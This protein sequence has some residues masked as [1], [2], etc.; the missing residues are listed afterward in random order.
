LTPSLLL[1][2]TALAAPITEVGGVDPLEAELPDLPG[3]FIP[4]PEELA[5]SAADPYR[6][7]NGTGVS[8]EDHPAVVALAQRFNNSL[9]VFCTGS[10]I[11]PDWI[12][13]A[14]HCIDSPR[15]T[16]VIFGGNL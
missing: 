1:L 6:I 3:F 2:N 10:L 11:T 4:V 16:V 13:T 14:A 8:A 15:N 12:L 5:P 7:W 9:F